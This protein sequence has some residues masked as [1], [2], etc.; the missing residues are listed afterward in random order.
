[1]ADGDEA[2]T[3]EADEEGEDGEGCTGLHT[4][5]DI[6]FNLKHLHPTTHEVYLY[7]QLL[8]DR[9]GGVMQAGLLLREF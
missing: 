2:Q 1:M 5:T 8:D 7:G 9:Q 6:G 4:Y 3:N